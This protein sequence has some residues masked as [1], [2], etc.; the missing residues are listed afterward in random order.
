LAPLC[1]IADDVF[2]LHTDGMPPATTVITDPPLKMTAYEIDLIGRV[3]NYGWQT[4][5][6][7][8][9]DNDA[10]AFSYTTGFWLTADAPEV[11]V[12]DFPSNLSHD[13]FG[14]MMKQVQSGQHFPTGKPIEGILSNEV[15]YLFPVKPEVGVQYLRSSTWFYRLNKFPAVQLVWADRAGLFPWDVKFD[16]ALAGL[17]PDLSPRG[18]IEE[19]D[20][21]PAGKSNNLG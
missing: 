13:V 9:S 2:L 19:L 14:H 15:V 6:V 10:P 3:R 4:T 12:F 1:L 7:G 16:A 8:A 5:S 11:I 17:Q 18:W 21:A 20:S